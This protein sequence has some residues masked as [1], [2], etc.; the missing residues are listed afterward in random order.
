MGFHKAT[1][2]RGVYG[3][4]SKIQ[5]ELDE[6]RDAESQGQ[7]LMLLIELADI[8]GAVEGVATRYGFTLEQLTAFA[9]LR[10]QVAREEKAALAKAGL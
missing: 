9:R 7:D 1:I 4:L 2:E 6:A 10:T 8:V 3:Q 5:E